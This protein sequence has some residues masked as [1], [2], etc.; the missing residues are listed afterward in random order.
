[1][2]ATQKKVLYNRTAAAAHY[3]YT[4]PMTKQR[5][6]CWF[7]DEVTHRAKGQM[8]KQEFPQLQGIALFTTN[9]D[10]F[11]PLYRA[12]RFMQF[13]VSWERPAHMQWQQE[14]WAAAASF[15]D[16]GQMHVDSVRMKFDD[17]PLS[18]QLQAGT[19]T[20]SD[21]SGW[22]RAIALANGVDSACCSSCTDGQPPSVCPSAACALA[23]SDLRSDVCGAALEGLWDYQDSIETGHSAAL[24]ALEADCQRRL[25]ADELIAEA[26]LRC[27]AKAAGHR[28]VQESIY[29]PVT[30]QLIRDLSQCRFPNAD[31]D[32]CLSSPCQNGGTCVDVADAAAQEQPFYLTEIGQPCPK[33]RELIG[34]LDECSY[35]AATLGLPDASASLVIQSHQA[36]RTAGCYANPSL[37][38]NPRGV[39]GECYGPQTC[40]TICRTPTSYVCACPAGFV[41]DE[42]EA[43]PERRFCNTRACCSAVRSFQESVGAAQTSGFMGYRETCCDG[44]LER[45]VDG[46]EHARDYCVY[47]LGSSN[48][49]CGEGSVVSCALWK[50]H[51]DASC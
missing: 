33:E 3:D 12:G 48:Y 30:L 46:I 38:F 1:M 42:C 25:T 39:P 18:R 45:T 19:S 47:S 34:T 9:V 50:A 13:G 7:E 49:R 24:S 29:V 26:Y 8:L 6:Q 44:E 21:S 14:M 31:Q 4:D 28:R 15:S 22:D 43:T 36:S 37:W 20:C 16:G 10:Y 11:E 35:A 5:H 32:E 2:V 41:G 23:V 51:C 27:R 40:R 17:T